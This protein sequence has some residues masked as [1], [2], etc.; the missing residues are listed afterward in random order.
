MVKESRWAGR[1]KATVSLAFVPLYYGYAVNSQ[2]L[3]GVTFTDPDTYILADVTEAD[4]LQGIRS[5]GKAARQRERERYTQ[6]D[7]V[8][9]PSMGFWGFLK[10]SLV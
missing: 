6:R 7:R 3:Q 4:W 9:F 1:A 2:Q 8:L 5:H 10:G